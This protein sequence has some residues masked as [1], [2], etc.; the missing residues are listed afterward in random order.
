MQFLADVTIRCPECRGTR[1]RPETLEVTYRG[2][3]IAEVLDLTVREAFGFFRHKPKVLVAAAAPA[4]RGARI[5]PP[6]PAGDHALGRRGAAV[7]ARRLAGLDARGHHPAPR[8]RARRCTSSTS[9]RR[10][11]IPWTSTSCSECF[12]SLADQ[13]H[14]PLIVEHNPQVMLAADW[15]IDLGPDAGDAGGR[16][17]ADGT[18]EDVSRSGTF[19]GDVLAAELATTTGDR[20]RSL[21]SSFAEPSS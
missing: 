1:Y 5:P 8:R 6:G 14:T 17:V 20:M 19:T 15:I 10:A 13:G 9:R 12:Q 3:N 16:I 4:R 18:P 2:K 11:C 21:A 7:E